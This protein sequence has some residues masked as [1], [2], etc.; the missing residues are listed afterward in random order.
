MLSDVPAIGDLVPGYEATNWEGI[1]T[2]VS[3]TYDDAAYLPRL[4]S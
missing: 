1:G 4:P 2:P 3:I